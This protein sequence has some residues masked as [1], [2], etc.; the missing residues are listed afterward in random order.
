MAFLVNAA[1]YNIY[2]FKGDFIRMNIKTDDAP[3]WARLVYN[4][5]EESNVSKKKKNW[6]KNLFDTNK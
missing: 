6:A 3:E 5:L 2:V 4:C 1:V